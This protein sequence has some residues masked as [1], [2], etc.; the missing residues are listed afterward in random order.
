MTLTHFVITRFC[1]RDPRRQRRRPMDP[2]APRNV[3]LHLRLLETTCLPG[4]RAQTNRSFTW[5]LLIDWQ[6]AQRHRRHFNPLRIRIRRLSHLL[7][8]IPHAA[9]WRLRRL[10]GRLRARLSRLPGPEGGRQGGRA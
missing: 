2:L 8:K 4:L 3:D 6:A 5:V 9:A 7:H 10:T 1:L